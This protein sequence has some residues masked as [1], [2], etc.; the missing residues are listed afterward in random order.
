VPARERLVGV[1][2]VAAQRGC[3]CVRVQIGVSRSSAYGT[4]GGRLCA[5]VSPRFFS[6]PAR[7]YSDATLTL[8]PDGW[9][10]LPV[11]VSSGPLSSAVGCATE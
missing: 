6:A 10:W 9:R 7:Q 8:R 11:G 2:Q 5:E 1:G 4:P 3:H